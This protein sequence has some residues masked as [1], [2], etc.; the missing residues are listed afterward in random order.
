NITPGQTP[1]GSG[2]IT[3]MIGGQ[4]SPEH[5]GNDF[6]LRGESQVNEGDAAGALPMFERV[7]SLPQQPEE[8]RAFTT[9]FLAECHHK[10]GHTKEALAFYQEALVS[11]V[12]TSEPQVVR[13]SLEGIREL[14][15]GEKLGPLNFDASPQEVDAANAKATAEIAAADAA[16]NS[17][18]LQ[19]ALQHATTAYAQRAAKPNL[20]ARAA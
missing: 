7:Y 16:G 3:F 12:R 9:V 18:D 14:R 11:P 17:G 4:E 6:F 10:L 13:M 19:G 15:M 20:R 5:E 1:I 8:R 2:P